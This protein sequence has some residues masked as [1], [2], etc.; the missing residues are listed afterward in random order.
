MLGYDANHNRTNIQIDTV[1]E[2]LIR[3][4]RG[5]MAETDK[6]YR[7]RVLQQWGKKEATDKENQVQQQGSNSIRLKSNK[8][9][10][11]KVPSST[12]MIVPIDNNLE[13]EIIVL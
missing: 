4:E 2:L 8:N 3:K 11:H 6:F 12:F 9:I 13:G 7:K 10:R 5:M 1:W